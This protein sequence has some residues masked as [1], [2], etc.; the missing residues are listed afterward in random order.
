MKN[1]GIR[2]SR[3]ESNELGEVREFHRKDPIGSDRWSNRGACKGSAGVVQWM[4][5]KGTIDRIRS[6]K[7][8]KMTIDRDYILP[9]GCNWSQWKMQWS[10]IGKENFFREIDNIPVRSS[11][12]TISTRLWTV[13]EYL[14]DF[15]KIIRIDIYIC[16][17]GISQARIRWL[18]E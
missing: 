14:D 18:I 11:L 4:K 5:R 6:S 9:I 3:F 10:A 2:I 16:R 17:Y 15:V 7:L 13:F 12:I 1:R 8:W